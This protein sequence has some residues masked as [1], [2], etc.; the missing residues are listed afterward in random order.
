MRVLITG[1][2]G[3][4][5]DELV[6]IFGAEDEVIGLDLGVNR[7]A[8]L[9]YIDCDICDAGA[10]SSAFQSS[11]CDWL[12]HTAAMTNVDGCELDPSAAHKV[13]AEG[14]AHV[15]DACLKL[16]IP[17]V[18]VSTDYV[19]DGKKSRPYDES[20]APHPLSVYG[21]SKWEGE[22][23]WRSRLKRGFVVRTSWLFGKDGRNFVRAIAE[24]A[25]TGER[26]PVVYDQWG[27]PTYA[28]D[29]ATALKRFIEIEKR[30][31]DETP[32]TLHFAN[33]GA[34]SRYEWARFIVGEMGLPTE[35]VK[36]VPTSA[37]PYP[38]ARPLRGILSLQ[39]WKKLCKEEPRDIWSVTSAYVRNHL[40]RQ[41]KEEGKVHELQSH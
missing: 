9:R 23:N 20:D 36:P 18:M 40:L 25:L 32:R 12:I 29:L 2:N 8:G 34:T 35:L 22:Q 15:A 13:N 19:F 4:L 11:K 10:V 39:L 16:G 38:A 33:A 21:R 6:R 27:S 14:T 3:M 31:G 7:R 26:F 17:A 37:T 30:L 5:G 24:R 41:L 1:S 28:W